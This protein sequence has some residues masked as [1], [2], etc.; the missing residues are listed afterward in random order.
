M[1]DLQKTIRD[2]AIG[3]IANHPNGVRMADL[4]REVLDVLGSAATSDQVGNAIWNIYETCSDQVVKIGRG[5]V[6]LISQSNSLSA[7]A[8]A[9]TS[10]PL[11]MPQIV[12]Q[13]TSVLGGASQV[14]STNTSAS[15][16]APQPVVQRISEEDFYQSFAEYLRDSLDEVTKVVAVG[17]NYF[18][19]KW[20]TPDVIGI[21]MSRY[22]EKYQFPMEIVSAE[23]KISTSGDSIITAFGQACSYRI[24]S[25]KV[26]LVLPATIDESDLDRILALCIV[27]GIGL[28]LF[29]AADKDNPNYDIRVWAVKNEPDKVYAKLALDNDRCRALFE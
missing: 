17:G 23:I 9:S 19:G 10:T 29:N 18:K 27:S 11:S 13:S 20:N 12:P 8:T 26:Y 16:S 21:Y 28:V 2:A 15:T 4:K 6:T 22:F 14:T 1:Q 3:V 5:I 24:F 25:H 7:P